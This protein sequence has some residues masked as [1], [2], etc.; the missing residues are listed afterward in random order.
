M[1]DSLERQW[2]G[3]AIPVVDIAHSEPTNLNTIDY[4]VLEETVKCCG[5]NAH[6]MPSPYKLLG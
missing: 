3:L 2:F 6:F 4:F 1:P 5:Y